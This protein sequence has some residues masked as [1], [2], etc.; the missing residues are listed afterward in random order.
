MKH[1]KIHWTAFALAAFLGSTGVV[2]AQAQSVYTGDDA[3]EVA[4]LGKASISLIDAISAA[5]RETSGKA[6][7]AQIEVKKDRTY[8]EV[9]VF[10]GGVIKEVKVDPSSGK[11]MEVKQD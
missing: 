11:I 5:E 6:L 4:A 2:F 7:E 9:D 8:F 1:K 10:A 3:E